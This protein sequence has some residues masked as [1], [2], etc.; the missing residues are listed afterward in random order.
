MLETVCRAQSS[1]L[2]RPVDKKTVLYPITIS[3]HHWR[4]RQRHHSQHSP[5]SY[6]IR[7]LPVHQNSDI[8]I[9]KR[10]A[11]RKNLI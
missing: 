4:H 2:V 9:L 3:W 6:I 1:Q 10:I 5:S 7:L 11:R 8:K